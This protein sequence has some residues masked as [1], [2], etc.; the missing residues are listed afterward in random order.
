MSE[1]G[2]VSAVVA[3]PV[4]KADEMTLAVH[5]PEADAR[6]SLTVTVPSWA[7]T[8]AVPMLTV[9][10]L[11]LSGVLMLSVPAS[12]ENEVEVGPPVR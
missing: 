8:L 2:I 3:P 10:R 7:C 12:T 1:A 6:W 9:P 11:A 4:T 5:S